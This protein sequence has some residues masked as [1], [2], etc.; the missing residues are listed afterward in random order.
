[1]PDK[2][3]MIN[4][5]QNESMQLCNFISMSKLSSDSW[6]MMWTAYQSLTNSIASHGKK[7]NY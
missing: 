3:E 2:L 7:W 6:Y 5:E 4:M 1:M